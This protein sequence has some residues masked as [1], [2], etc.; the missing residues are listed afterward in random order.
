MPY[1]VP[2]KRLTPKKAK[3]RTIAGLRRLRTQLDAEMPQKTR[4]SSLILGTWNIR[5]FDDNRFNSGP[6]STEDFYYLAEIIS[7]FDILAVQE[8]CDD[9]APLEKLMRILGRDYD[10][11]LTDITEGRSGNDERLGFVFQKE[12]VQ[13]KNIAGEIVLPDKLLI[14]DVGKKR[15]FARTPFVC[16]FQAGWFKFSFATVHIYFGNNSGE[17]YER[18][19]KEIDSVAKAIA[20]RAKKQSSSQILV[21]DF[22]IKKSGSDGYNALEKNGFTIVQNKE[23]SNKDQTKFYDQISFITRENHLLFSESD[24]SNGVFQFFD[25]IYR[26]ED[27]NAFKPDL[28]KAVGRKIKKLEEESIPETQ[29]L[30]DNTQSA[31][32][33]VKYAKTLLSQQES[34]A[35]WIDHETDDTKLK[36]YYLSDWRTFH[37]SDHL[38]LWVE[39]QIDFSDG[40]LDYI[41][42][43]A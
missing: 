35:D 22:N 2:L 20:R 21:G 16:A 31:S 25:S 23:G 37:G 33:K 19:V 6:R 42:D 28:L 11:I 36:N 3:A 38:P 15:Q 7:R 39:L 18:R 24:T 34:L 1:Y 10:Y 13:F 43:L 32:Q 29:R 8:I 12:K 26:E 40:Y 27:F 41:S 17:K 5:N 9:L 14:S 30:H 4:D